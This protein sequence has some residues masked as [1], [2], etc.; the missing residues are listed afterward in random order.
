MMRIACS[1][2]GWFQWH[3]LWHLAAAAALWLQYAFLRSEQPDKGD[4]GAAPEACA[5]SQ[6]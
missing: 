5:C 6:L 2:R 3:S 1:P 4:G